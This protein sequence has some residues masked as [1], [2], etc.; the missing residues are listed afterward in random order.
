MVTTLLKYIFHFGIS[1]CLICCAL[2]LAEGSPVAAV[3]QSQVPQTDGG[4]AQMTPPGAPTALAKMCSA[5]NPPPCATPPRVVFSPD[6]GFSNQARKAKYQGTCTLMIVV[7]A[8]GRITNIRVVSPVGMGLDQKAI[9]ALKRWRFKPAMQDGKP[10][11][12]EM[13][14]E[15][16]FHLY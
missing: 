8:E 14:V 13:A 16:D 7:S 2:E 4:D 11:P 3:S 15:V 12:V 9:D 1:A 5:K 10:V 6:P